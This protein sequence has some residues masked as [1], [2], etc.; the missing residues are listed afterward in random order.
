MNLTVKKVKIALAC[1]Q[2]STLT[3]VLGYL[4]DP[5]KGPSSQAFNQ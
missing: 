1:E 3:H 2:R 4:L 5:A